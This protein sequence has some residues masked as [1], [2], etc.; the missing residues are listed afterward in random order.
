MSIIR[1]ELACEFPEDY[2]YMRW[3]LVV[4]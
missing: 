2:T 4:Y 1:A 3:V